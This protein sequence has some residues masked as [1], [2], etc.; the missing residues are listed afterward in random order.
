MDADLITTARTIDPTVLGPRVRSARLRAGLTQAEAAGGE[1]STAYVSRIEAGQRR[2]DL[3]VLEGLAGRLRTSV[4]ELLI[5]TSRDD[6]A[7]LRTRLGWARLTLETGD[8]AVALEA[9]DGLLA[10]LPDEALPDVRRESRHVRAR[11]LEVSGDHEQAVAELEDLEVEGPVD[12]L[13]LRG[14]T[15]LCRC[16]RIAGDLNRAVDVGERALTRMRELDLQG[17]EESVALVVTVAAAYFERGDVHHASRMCQRAV[18]DAERLDSPRARAS[19]YWNASVVESRRGRP[20][21]ALALAERAVG[22][23]E[24]TEGRSTALLR[25]QLGIIQLRM[26]PPMAQDA[27]DNLLGA[28]AELTLSDANPTEVATNEL[29]IARAHFHLGELDRASQQAWQAFESTRDRSPLVA[30]D[31]LALLGQLSIVA[32]EVD[33]ARLR[34]QRAVM[35]LSAVGSDREAAQLWFE[36]AELLGS[37]GENDAALDAYRRAA[38]AAGLSPA[39]LPARVP[40]AVRST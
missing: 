35:V 18:R 26:D 1:L 12:L 27:L 28:R 7:E 17:V 21:S 32:G 19:A 13:W 10:D 14:M 9:I 33:E 4:E 31:A 20:R 5:G 2:P 40:E 23:L 39:P 37:V 3:T 24:S 34:F 11:A 8:P 25:S 16:H 6:E 15:A 29:A 36:L 38:V 30:A 22:L